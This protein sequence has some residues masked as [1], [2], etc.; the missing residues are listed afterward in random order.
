MQHLFIVVT[1]SVSLEQEPGSG[2][3]GGH[4]TCTTSVVNHV[5]CTWEVRRLRVMFQGS[6][7]VMV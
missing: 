7:S 2:S 4:A 1:L 6:V 3:V 5:G